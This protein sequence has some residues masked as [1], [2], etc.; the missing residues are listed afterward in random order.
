MKFLNRWVGDP[1]LCIA[2][3]EHFF[4]SPRAC[5][6]TPSSP[7]LPWQDGPSRYTAENGPSGWPSRPVLVR[8]RTF[9]DRETAMK[10]TP[11][12]WTP[13]SSIMKSFT[14]PGRGSRLLRYRKWKPLVL[15]ARSL[16]LQWRLIIKDRFVHREDTELS[17][18]ASPPQRM[19]ERETETQ[20]L[21]LD[22]K[23]R[24]VFLYTF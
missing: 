4:Y 24:D 19:T 16:S 18:T 15:K 23:V 17:D 6:E 7:S 22:A 12:S 1:N 3:H 13:A 2:L 10:H 5:A 21:H 8:F 11:S 9:H 20:V 14:R